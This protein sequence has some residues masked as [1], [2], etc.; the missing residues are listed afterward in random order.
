M[1]VDSDTKNIAIF[2]WTD[3]GTIT[4]SDVI[5]F[6][7][8]QLNPGSTVNDFS[9]PLKSEVIGKMDYLLQ[10]FNFD[11]TASECV[12]GAGISI[13]NAIIRTHLPLRREMRIVPTI[14]TSAANT[15]KGSNE[16]AEAVCTSLDTALVGRH[17]FR[18]S[19]TQGGTT[20]SA[21][22]G[23]VIRRDG[24]DT[25]WIMADARF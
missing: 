5:G 23:G 12:P 15:F 2:V 24:T 10:R 4:A 17:S 8:W 13:T 18:V 9:S 6:S 20:W 19:C 14:T 22:D 3:D 21:G 25:S 7:E 1:T 16:V 11:G